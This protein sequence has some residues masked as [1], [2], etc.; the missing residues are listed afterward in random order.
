MVLS[1]LMNLRKI[2]G[3]ETFHRIA[4]APGELLVI[5]KTLDMYAWIMHT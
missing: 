3:N 4:Y 1:F 5:R 2:T